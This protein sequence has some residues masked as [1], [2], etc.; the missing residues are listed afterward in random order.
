MRTLVLALGLA[1]ASMSSAAQTRPVTT[2]DPLG[3]WTFS[4]QDE[5]GNAISGTMEI[6]GKPG[7]YTG[8][9]VGGADQPLQINDVFTSPTGMVIMAN[10]PDGGVA[11]IKVWTDA[12]GKIQCGW[13]PVAKVIPATVGRAK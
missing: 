7:A 6:T 10:L 11:V 5:N 12:G 4:T 3:K 8:T 13:G 1:L 9:I 2:F